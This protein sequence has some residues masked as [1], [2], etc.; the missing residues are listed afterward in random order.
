MSNMHED[1]YTVQVNQSIN[2]LIIILYTSQC[3]AKYN[4][5]VAQGDDRD[6]HTVF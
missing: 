1:V 5:A 2:Q 6:D 4:I 3:Y